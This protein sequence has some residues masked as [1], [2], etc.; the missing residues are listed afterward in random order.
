MHYYGDAARAG[1][2]RDFREGL[3]LGDGHDGAAAVGTADEQ[4]VNL[5][6]QIV[7]VV[8]K[9]GYIDFSVRIERGNNCRINT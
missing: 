6:A 1:L 4:S 2:Y 3:A 8:L 5:V 9:L 7:D